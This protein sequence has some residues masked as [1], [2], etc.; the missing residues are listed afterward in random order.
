MLILFR[1]SSDPRMILLWYSFLYYLISSP[2][3]MESRISSLYGSFCA[4]MRVRASS[5]DTTLYTRVCV[6]ACV[7]A[8]ERNGDKMGEVHMFAVR[9]CTSSHD[10]TLYTD[11]C[12]CVC[13]CV[14]TRERAKERERER[15]KVRDRGAYVRKYGFIS[16]CVNARA[17]SPSLHHRRYGAHI[18]IMYG[19]VSI[20]TNGLPNMTWY[21]NTYIWD[22]INHRVA[23]MIWHIYI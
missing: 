16:E 22:P 15:E 21:I 10:T 23:P 17:H 9:V 14:C 6:Y 12:V 13:V 8:W 20:V 5:R 11:A 18:H 2:A 4:W 1:Y 19:C 3:G 7:C